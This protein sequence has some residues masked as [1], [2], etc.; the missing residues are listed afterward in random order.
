VIQFFVAIRDDQE[1]IV[2]LAGNVLYLV[3]DLE[4]WV[5]H[6]EEVIVDL[7]HPVDL[8]EAILEAFLKVIVGG[9]IINIDV[10]FQFEV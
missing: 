8:T 1:V 4:V 6:L 7:A 2:L 9:F 3:Q 5:I 10:F